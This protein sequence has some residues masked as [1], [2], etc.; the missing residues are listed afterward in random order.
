MGHSIAVYAAALRWDAELDLKV[1]EEIG[2][3]F[4][5]AHPHLEITSK[6]NE[7][8]QG[9]QRVAIGARAAE[10]QLPD[11]SGQAHRLSALRGKLV[12]LDFWASWC[13]PCRVENPKYAKLYYKYRD[14]GLA[15]Y[16][17]SLDENRGQW[18]RAAERDGIAWTNV[19]DLAGY[20]SPTARDYSI[21]ALPINFL[22]DGESRIIAK[23]I[24]GEALREKIAAL[25]PDESRH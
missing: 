7:A 13:P 20:R 9:F 23:N 12:L 17:V 5:T 8:V 10:I 25:L 15:I 21:S 24:R 16:S 4:Q 6:L 22:L 1:M 11:A 18:L 14:R 3:K 2:E 19:S